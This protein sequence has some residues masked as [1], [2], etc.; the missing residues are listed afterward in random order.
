MK[1]TTGFTGGGRS[2]RNNYEFLKPYVVST[3]VQLKNPDEFSYVYSSHSTIDN[4]MQE[5]ETSGEA[6]LVCNIP[7]A[8]VA[9]ILTSTQA[10]EV[11]KE[12]NLLGLSRKSL[13]EKRKAV[14]SHVCTVSCN[15]HVTTFKPVKKKNSLLKE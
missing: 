13:E 7:L 14:K 2:A 6:R 4:A 10:T 3:K 1:S 8:L 5:I 9:H 15:R 11:A 12:H